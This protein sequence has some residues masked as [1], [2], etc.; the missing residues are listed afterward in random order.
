VVL[1]ETDR[2][3]R[4]GSGEDLW[5]LGQY[6][7]PSRQVKG[8]SL[9]RCGVNTAPVS[10]RS[11]ACRPPARISADPVVWS[12]CVYAW[13]CTSATVEGLA[14][15]GARWAAGQIANQPTPVNGCPQ[16]NR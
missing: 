8:I 5:V 6:A 2:K 13:L 4:T 15:G 1:R 3:D 12:G 9:R 10:R 14:R 7:H 11:D 16:R